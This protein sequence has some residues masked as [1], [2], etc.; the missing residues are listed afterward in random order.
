MPQYILLLRDVPEDYAD[1][2]RQELAALVQRYVD[3]TEDLKRSK[4]HVGS[5]KL[6]DGKLLRLQDGRPVASDGPYAEAKDVIGGAFII[7]AASLEEAESIA[8]GSPH[9][10]GRNAIEI[11]PVDNDSCDAVIEEA[12]R[13]REKLSV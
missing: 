4:H 11:R 8:R 13:E 1:L 3:W 6:G 7:E 9:L 12:R 2:G 10:R 5:F